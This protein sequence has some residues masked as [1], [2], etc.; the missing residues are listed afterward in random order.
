MT[1]GGANM[2]GDIEGTHQEHSMTEGTGIPPKSTK[3]KVAKKVNTDGGMTG[4]LSQTEG[5]ARRSYRDY[6][7]RYQVDD[8]NEGGSINPK[9]KTEG[10][11]KGSHGTQQQQKQQKQ[12]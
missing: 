12:E 10:T 7:Q 1:E 11:L 3:K 4:S 6:Y 9:H 5:K 2:P 8:S